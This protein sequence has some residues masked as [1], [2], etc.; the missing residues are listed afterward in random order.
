MIT[1][2]TDNI[3]NYFPQPSYQTSVVEGYLAKFGSEYSNLYNKTG[4]AYP[5]IAAYG[6]N[7]TINYG[8]S[9]YNVDG[10]SASTPTAASVFTLINDALIAKGESPLGFLNPWLY[11]Y[12][13]EAFTDVTSG[14]TKGCNTTGFTAMKGWDPAS[15][16]GTPVSLDS[17][18]NTVKDDADEFFT[19]FREAFVDRRMRL[20]LRILNASRMG[21]L[22]KEENFEQ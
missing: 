18:S 5:D 17:V 8:G 6:V 19:E 15:G 20:S 11:K 7:Y 16:F 2:L 12:G 1:L 3:S 4:R 21:M 10:T 14:N 22:D 9:F 13:Y